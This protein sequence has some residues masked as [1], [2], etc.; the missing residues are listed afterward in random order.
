MYGIKRTFGF[1]GGPHKNMMLGL[2]GGDLV[3]Q[4]GDNLDIETNYL[5][6]LV[7]LWKEGHIFG[8]GKVEADDRL[9]PEN[10]DLL[11]EKGHTSVGAFYIDRSLKR[12]FMWPT[13]HNLTK[14]P[15]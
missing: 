1:G 6:S 3:V 12:A 4:L 9:I 13:F 2:A 7:R 14:E 10:R 15:R 11:W 5:G 8:F